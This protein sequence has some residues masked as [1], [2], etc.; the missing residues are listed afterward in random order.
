[1]AREIET[2]ILDAD[3]EGDV[4]KSHVTERGK[5]LATAFLLRSDRSWYGEL[6]ILLK[7]DYM[8]HQKNYPKTLTDTGLGLVGSNATFRL[9]MS[10]RVL[11]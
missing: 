1:M 8:K 7:H 10:V 4:D 11:G 5:Y 3:T 2:L 9:Y 6:I